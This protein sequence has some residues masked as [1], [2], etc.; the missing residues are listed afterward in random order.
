MPTVDGL[1]PEL[2]LFLQ[3]QLLELLVDVSSVC[4]L[5]ELRYNLAAVVVESLVEQVCELLVNHADLTVVQTER[6]AVDESLDGR[7]LVQDDQV[8]VLHFKVDGVEVILDELILQV[9]DA[10]LAQV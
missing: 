5:S 10:S 2:P 1:L 7:Q 3:F 6:F 9:V 8:A 4:F